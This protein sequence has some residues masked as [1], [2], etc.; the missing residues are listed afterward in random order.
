MDH[1]ATLFV[2]QPTKGGAYHHITP[3]TL[4]K[5][6]VPTLFS[7][8]AANVPCLGA[9]SFVAPTEDLMESL[10]EGFV[11]AAE[12]KGLADGKIGGGWRWEHREKGWTN[13]GVFFKYRDQNHTRT[14]DLGWPWA[15]NA[16]S[17]FPEHLPNACG[18][19][20]WGTYFWI[21][22]QSVDL[23]KYATPI[24]PPSSGE[25]CPQK[26]L[27]SEDSTKSLGDWNLVGTNTMKHTQTLRHKILEGFVIQNHSEL[28]HMLQTFLKVLWFKTI[29]HTCCIACFMYQKHPRPRR[30]LQPWPSAKASCLRRSSSVRGGKPCF[31]HWAHGAWDSDRPFN[32][33]IDPA[34]GLVANTWQK[35]AKEE[36]GHVSRVWQNLQTHCRPL[37]NQ[38]TRW[39]SFM[40]SHRRSSTPQELHRESFP[41]HRM[42]PK[43]HRGMWTSSVLRPHGF[44]CLCA[45]KYVGAFGL[46]WLLA[47][48]R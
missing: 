21:D 47:W 48:I 28:A 20:L 16:T 24:Q 45:E 44:R 17:V 15:R 1:G 10:N 41:D 29:L 19:W 42:E 43:G 22:L 12:V 11:S 33:H 7:T 6:Q 36:N 14:L 9:P 34:I 18:T 23:W 2:E 40:N 27:G 39:T 35:N 13:W 38:K 32:G 30:S 26:V 5:S 25:Q 46:G 8:S 31:G 37:R 3:K 4:K